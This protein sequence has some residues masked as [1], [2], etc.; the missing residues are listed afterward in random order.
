MIADH[1]QDQDEDE[2]N[3]S[4]IV[5]GHHFPSRGR[6]SLPSQGEHILRTPFP[7]ENLS[8]FKTR[9]LFLLYFVLMAYLYLSD[10]ILLHKISVSSKNL[11]R[12]IATYSTLGS[13]EVW[14][15]GLSQG[16]RQ[17]LKDAQELL[18]QQKRAI[19]HM[20]TYQSY[21]LDPTYQ[22]LEHWLDQL[23]LHHLP[24]REHQTQ[25]DQQRS[26]DAEAIRVNQQVRKDDLFQLIQEFHILFEGNNLNQ[27]R[28][29]TSSSSC[30]SLSQDTS[31]EE[32]ESCSLTELN[33][34]IAMLSQLAQVSEISQFQ[35]KERIKNVVRNLSLLNTSFVSF[36]ESWQRGNLHPH[37]PDCPSCDLL[38]KS[39]DSQTDSNDL[40]NVLRDI[41]RMRMRMK[42]TEE[43]TIVVMRREMNEMIGTLFQDKD[44]RLHLEGSLENFIEK[45]LSLVS[46]DELEVHNSALEEWLQAHPILS[47]DHSISEEEIQREIEEMVTAENVRMD[48]LNLSLNETISAPDH[49]M[50]LVISIL[51]AGNIMTESFGYNLEL[52]LSNSLTHPY[53]ASYVDYATYRHG[54]KVYTANL[55]GLVYTSPSY[56]TQATLMSKILFH[57]GMDT[58]GSY[59][60]DLISSRYP[61]TPGHCYAIPGSVGNITVT[62]QSPVSLHRVGVYHVP[63]EEALPGTEQ[64]AMREF[65]VIGWVN[66]PSA[67]RALHQET[68][69]HLGDFRYASGGEGH[70]ALQLFDVIQ[71]SSSSSGS[72]DSFPS[73]SAVTFMIRSNH[74][75]P[76]YTCVYH[77][78]ALGVGS[79]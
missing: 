13:V 57:A 31:L 6:V 78:L 39:I 28:E 65:S 79:S 55:E 50:E 63:Y 52:N 47:Q 17:A 16:E 69:Y 3:E 74:G 18:S 32:L 60:Y 12:Q 44:V 59:S 73:F 25:A 27:D 49:L 30:C 70:A 37:L 38:L 51:D 4:E 76:D 19:S 67:N 64:T 40:K 42:L 66:K 62:F 11:I 72:F 45:E 20:K 34:S 68:G 22:R 58:R 56:L 54:G 29:V 36:E 41:L 21:T 14:E 75:N 1:D 7:T 53:A 5:H 24:L 46:H 26:Q 10:Q 71:S 43:E 2:L 33:K 35:M 9:L 8:L 15:W 23:R 48:L 61:P 77:L